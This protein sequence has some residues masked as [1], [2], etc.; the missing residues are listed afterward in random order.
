MLMSNKNTMVFLS[1]RPMYQ[2]L[3]TN[4]LFNFEFGIS[5]SLDILPYFCS[6]VTSQLYKVVE[7]GV[8]AERYR[9]TLISL[10]T[11]STVSA[12]IRTKGVFRDSEVSVAIRLRPIVFQ[13]KPTMNDDLNETTVY[14]SYPRSNEAKPS[15]PEG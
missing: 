11:Y 14:V 10:V 2:F 6:V 9:L 5:L 12:E 1:K 15:K 13:V 4:R 7:T 3:V 8:P